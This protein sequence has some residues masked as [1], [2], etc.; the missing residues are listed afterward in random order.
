MCRVPLIVYSYSCK[1]TILVF[2]PCEIQIQI[3][4]TKLYNYNGKI[5]NVSVKLKIVNGFG[6]LNCSSQCK[7]CMKVHSAHL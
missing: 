3:L 5:L 4:K 7:C 6:L 1:L 2:T